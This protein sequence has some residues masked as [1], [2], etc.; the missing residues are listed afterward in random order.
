MFLWRTRRSSSTKYR[1]VPVRMTSNGGA[2]HH[3]LMDGRSLCN[4]FSNQSSWS[5]MS[6]Y[7]T[8]D[9][10]DHLFWRILCQIR[11]IKYCAEPSVRES[12]KHEGSLQRRVNL[13]VSVSMPP[14]STG[15]TSS[16][17]RRLQ[18][19][20][21]QA[22]IATC[23]ALRWRQRYCQTRYTRRCWFIPPALQHRGC[24]AIIGRSAAISSWINHQ[25]IA[26]QQAYECTYNNQVNCITTYQEYDI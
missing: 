1:N 12:P 10:L 11:N 13:W 19:P 15:R 7:T 3:S 2:H 5:W 22:V 6:R 16:A 17:I 9:V 18:Q 23:H 14:A 8:Y 21:N 4:R 26:R 24:T 20:S 25:P